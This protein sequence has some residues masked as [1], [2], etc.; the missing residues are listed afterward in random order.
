VTE[1][2]RG[3]RNSDATFDVWK[4]KYAGLGLNYRQVT[5]GIDRRERFA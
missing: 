4:K 5:R 1:I 2:P 3:L